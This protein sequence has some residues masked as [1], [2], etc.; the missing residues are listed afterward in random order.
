MKNV[1]QY[2]RP[3]KVPAAIAVF[4]MLVE[5]T[6]E[7]IQ[8]LIMARIINEGIMAR[9]PDHVILW[10]GVLVGLS[11][12]AFLSGILN[13]YYASH[14]SQGF[15][16]DVRTNTFKKIQS[17]SYSQFTLFSS[18]SLM[19]RL[20]NDVQQVQNTLFMMLRIMLRAPLLIIGGLIMAF[21]VD[22]SLAAYL[23]VTVPVLF[24]F[25]IYIFSKGSRKFTIVQNRLDDVN[26]VMG[27]NLSGMKLIRAF[28][29]EGHEEKRFA[30]ANGRLKKETS[31]VLRFM[32]FTLPSLLLLMNLTIIMVLWY[33][34]EE[35]LG[36]GTDVGSVVAIINYATRITSSLSVFSFIVTAFSRA[37]ASAARIGEIL[38]TEPMMGDEGKVVLRKLQ[39]EITFQ[40]VGFRYGNH[41]RWALKDL[42]FTIHAGGTL[43]ILGQTGSG[44]STI[45]NM[46]PRLY[47]VTEGTVTIDGIDVRD[48]DQ[49]ELRM[50]IGI[51]PQSALLFTGSIKENLLWGN[52]QAS[53]EDILVACRDAQVA[54]L[55]NQLPEGMH[56]IVGQKG[57]NLSG[58]QR[59]R[60]SIARALI[61]KPGILLFDDSTSALDAR[62][63]RRLLDALKTYEATKIVV[64][65]KISTAMSADKIL[66]LKDG[67][68]IAEGTHHH[69]KEHSQLYRDILDSQMQQRRESFVPERDC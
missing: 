64:T 54:E 2:V 9:D 13:T 52:R 8:P 50:Q 14:T 6:V 68:K 57:V 15:G 39:G 61:R 30:K 35:I 63:E 20:T 38:K 41:D 26:T 32:E 60:L 16:Y 23:A 24:V 18:G 46:I 65:Q 28:Q 45:I 55:L 17:F 69:L 25:L 48:M 19:T 44:K 53:E 40:G 31:S 42:S 22:V 12:T 11:L 5:L 1:W 67:A 4:F 3:Y 47:D 10:G 34:N 36:G 29:R 33:G 66:L 58:G 43:A 56:S 7:L 49:R 21:V 27:E 59:Q 51:V 37:R 62:T